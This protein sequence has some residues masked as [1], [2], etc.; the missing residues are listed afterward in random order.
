MAGRPLKESLDFSGWD[1]NIF[2]NDPKIDKL[3]DAQGCVGFV[4]Y[5]YMCQKA[6]GSNGYY[7]SWC[8]DDSATTARKIGGGAGAQSVE[9]TVRYCLQIGLFDKR[10]FDGWKILTNEDIQKRYRQVAVTRTGNKV[11]K[12]Y[13]LLNEEE[14]AGLNFCTLKSNYESG[15][16][17]YDPL[18]LNYDQSKL[19]YDPPTVK[20][21]NS[22]VHNSIPPVTP[23]AVDNSESAEEPGFSWGTQTKNKNGGEEVSREGMDNTE[24]LRFEYDNGKKTFEFTDKYLNNLDFAY[25]KLNSR[26]EAIKIIEKIKDDELEFAHDNQIRDYIEKWCKNRNKDKLW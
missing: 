20:Y 26:N 14:S 13:W 7:Y 15:Q 12:E 5:F 8:Y 25:P 23:K 10:L 9:E 1:V 17:N 16:S 21:T 22:K 3:M 19:N 24:L 2:D 4:I 11:I 6:Y 18:K